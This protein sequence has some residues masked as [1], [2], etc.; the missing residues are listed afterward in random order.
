MT[1]AGVAGREKL[2]PI[3]GEKVFQNET[4]PSAAMLFSQETR[5]FTP[6][7]QQTG[8]SEPTGGNQG[9][10]FNRSV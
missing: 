3:R 8:I 6:M 2:R 10:I 5:P 1:V 9:L 7:D 4:K